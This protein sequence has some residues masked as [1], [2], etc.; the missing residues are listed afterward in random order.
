MKK[1]FYLFCVAQIIIQLLAGKGLLYAQCNDTNGLIAFTG[2]QIADAA[3]PQGQKDK[4]S[5]V[6]LDSLPANTAIRFTDRGYT[7]EPFQSFTDARSD[8]ELVW[9][10]T[11]G[12]SP[13]TTIVITLDGANTIASKGGISGY[14]G[15]FDLGLA[16]DQLFAYVNSPFKI[17]AAML[18]N[19]AGWDTEMAQLE[20]YPILSSSKSLNPNI[21]PRQTVIISNLGEDA[22]QA[23]LNPIT[24]TGSRTALRSQLFAGTFNISNSLSANLVQLSASPITWSA[25]A[26]TYTAIALNNTT[27][28][29]TVSD[30]CYI[31]WQSSTDGTTFNDVIDGAN[32]TG[33]K[34]ANLTLV[35]KPLTQDTWFRMRLT[36]A[37]TTYTPAIHL[38]IPAIS[39]QP[40][41]DMVCT[42]SPTSFTVAATGT[43]LSYQ[44]QVNAGSGFTNIANST[45]YSGATAPTLNISNVT[46]LN[47]YKYRVVVSSNI[48]ISDTSTEA[49]L[50]V[51]QLSV[52]QLADN[53][54]CFGGN[55][56][57]VGLHVLTHGVQPYTYSW[58][59]QGTTTVISTDAIVSGLSAGSYTGTITDAMGC[60]ITR[61][62][63]VEQPAA[64]LEV[65]SHGKTNVSCYGGANGTAR[66]VVTGGTLP[67]TYSWDYAPWIT[68]AEATGLAAGTYTVT[69]TDAKNC[70]TTQQFI[71]TQPAAILSVSFVDEVHVSCHAGT[72]GQ[73]TAAVTGG[74]Q[75]YTYS[76]VRQGTSTQIADTQTASGLTAGTYTVNVTDVNYC[77]IISNFTITQPA[78]ALSV[79]LYNKTDVTAYGGS[80]GTIQVTA[81][82][83][84]PNY[85][86]VWQRQVG[87][88]WTAINQSSN[89][90]TNLTPGIYRVTVT[91]YKG[92][93]Q[94][95]AGIIVTQPPNQAPV[96]SNL[97]SDA[98][99]WAGVGNTVTLDASGNAGVSDAE[100]DALNGGLGNYSG[101][102]LTLQR[103]GN[104]T[105]A[106]VFGFNT[107][108]SSFNVSGNT[109]QSRGSTFATF[110]NTGG[111]LT[112]SFTSSGTVATKALVNEVLQ[113]IMYRNDTP[114]GDA[115]IG[116]TFSD[117]MASSS[118]NVLVN[119][120]NIYITNTI[121]TN[122]INVAD[123]ISFNE[124]I[125]IALADA[126]GTQTL[127]FANTF[128]N[129]TVNILN[130]A[131]S[132]NLT[133]DISNA[134]GLVLTGG[135]ITVSSG[136]IL[137]FSNSAGSAAT[138]SSS[139][140]GNGGINKAGA[141]LITL[142]G[143]G[144]Y[145]GPTQVTA[146]TLSVRGSSISGLSVASGATLAGTGNVKSITL[147]N[148][149]ILSPGASGNDIGT[150]TV[151]ENLQLNAGGTLAIQING[152]TAGTEYDQI[153]V[154]GTVSIQG[155][156]SVTHGYMPGQGD[157]YSIIVNDAADVITGTFTGLP[158]GGTITAAGNST[159]L[160]AS[161]IG[162]TG[163]DFTLTAPI[164]EAPV[165]S[166]LNGDAVSYTEGGAAASIDAGSNATVTDSDS[167]D[168]NGG[169]V[170]VAITAN[171]VSAEDVLSIRNEGTGAGQIGVSGSNVTYG[172]TTIGAWTGG[173]GVNDLVFSFNGNSSVASVQSLIRNL[174]YKNT[175][176]ADPS[177][178][179][180]TVT[181]TVNDGDGGTSTPANVSV[182][183]T[184]VNDA[185]TLTATDLNQTFTEG[186]SAVSLFS[187]T[188]IS[189]IE[190]GQ[191][192]SKLT[193]TVANVSDGNQE[194]LKIDGFDVP[195]VIGTKTTGT[196]GLT[197]DLSVSGSSVIVQLS[198]VG[199]IS[200]AIMQ[201][202]V[203][204]ITYRNTST[205]PNTANRIITLSSIQDNGGIANGGVDLTTLSI[206][207]TVT[208][209]A[210]NNVPIVTTS[211]GNTTY[212]EGTAAVVDAALTVSDP[213]NTTLAS[214]TVAITGNFQSGQDV[215]EFANNGTTMGNITAAY[216]AG[217]G[218]LTL[219][220]AGSTAT[221]AQWQAALRTVKYGNSSQN[222]STANRTISFKVHDSGQESVAATKT[223]SVI[224]V[225]DAPV[226]V[227]DYVTVTEDIPATGNV[228]TND[229]DPEGN[230]LTASLVI[231]P[232]NGT[233]VLNADGSFTYTPNANYA[234]RDSLQ[235]QVCDN[236][237]PSKCDTAWLYL[238]VNPVNDAP[239][240]S[241]P[242][243]IAVTED[244]ASA[245]TGISFS[246]VDA[247]AN[248]V[249]VTLS[250][251]TGTLSATSG[252][253]ITV[254]G[255]AAILT[256]S[257][258]VSDINA[259]VAAGAVTFTTVSNATSNVILTVSI[260]DNAHTGGTALSD[261]KTTPLLVTAVNDAPVNSVPGAQSV[262][263]DATL[264]F[265]SANSNLISISDVDAGSSDVQV[266]LVATN[267]RM[268]LG[269]TSGLLFSV[270]N[271]T[272][273]ASLTFKGTIAN[274]NTALN[275]LVF[276]PTPG[277]N[278]PASLQIIT[279]DLGNSGSGGAKTD[280]DYIAI[281]VN[282]VS[283]K[284]ISVSASTANGTYK[285][286]DVIALTVTFDQTV[287]VNTV[288]G[289]P[290]L[291]LETGA[292]D[293]MSTYVSGSGSNTL[294]FSYTVQPGD[295]SADLDYTSTAAL[296]L[297]GATIENIHNDI[298]ILTLPTV[299][300]SNSIAGQR[301]IVIDGVVPTVAMVAVPTN[302]Y[303]LLNQ[304][305]DFT[306]YFSEAVLVDAI[307]GTPRLSLTIG[308]QTAYADY[309]SGSGSPALVFRY[310][311]AAGLEDHDGVAVGALSLNGGTI[312]DAAGNNAVL[313]L[314]SV[315]NTTGVN[316]DSNPPVVPANFTA[317]G[318]DA[319]ISLA[320]EANMETDFEKYI[321]YV[322]PDGG[323]KTYLT[324]IAK[325]TEYYTYSGLPNGASYEF[326][327]I[328][329]DQ[330]GH[331]SGEAL[332]SAKTMGEQSISF[333]ALANLTYGQQGVVLTASATSNLPVSFVSSDSNIAEVYQDNNDG[334]KWKVNAKKVG[335]VTITAAQGGNNVYLPAASVP[336]SLTIVPAMLTV[337][338]D[339][340][341]KVYG[342]VDPALTYM[343]KASDLRNGDAA[344]VVSGR[345][346]RA[347]GEAVGNHDITNVDLAA[348]N[349]A[350]NYVKSQLS[351]T[352][353][354]LTVTAD[355]KTKVYGGAD[356]ALTYTVKASDLRNGDAATVVS[357]S[358]TRAQG[359]AVGNYDITNVDLAASNYAINYVKSALSITKA[360]LTVTADAKTKVYGTNDPALTYI[361]TGFKRSDSKSILIGGLTRVEGENV[362]SYAIQRGTLA[363]GDNYTI[364]Y[365]GANLMITKATLSGL[366][367]VN[368]DVVYDGAVKSIQLNGTLPTGV[369]VVYQNNDKIN[370]G[371]YDVK[372][373]I[374]ET[375][376]YFGTSF[377]A[378]LL[379][380]KAKQTIS[381]MAPEVLA[382]D[383][384]KISL[385]VQSSSNLPV[386][387][388]VD[389]PMVATVSGTD[390]NVLRL[391]T[392]RITAT[393]AG[394]ENYEAAAPVNVSV[395]VA[396]DASAKLPIIV[397]QAVSPNG[398]GIN[399]FLIIEGIRDYIDNKVTIFDKNGVVLAEIQ[400]YD[401][402]DRVFFGKDH[403]DGTYY[404]YIDVKDG[405]TWKREK[406]FFVIKR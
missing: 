307:G 292:I 395:R 83:G 150:L 255:T 222:P 54:S 361:A 378:T 380:R 49:T 140:Y 113:R 373:I 145:T 260:T 119:T 242:T 238:T 351:I 405:N 315:G 192:I 142:I 271:G 297:N 10:S 231:A 67:Y 313:T 214:A 250:V 139:I 362:G 368:K 320:W 353:A 355:A 48:A 26:P 161:Y 386:Q 265:N 58:V 33:A 402:R 25:S 107:L 35:N 79:T 117:G 273:D 289:T 204:G 95:S 220:S 259:F 88:G 298:A 144:S 123:G 252:M 177:T 370:A 324:D 325:G 7:G 364:S 308:G 311:V 134:S 127:I 172:G 360:V 359:E 28:S 240:V 318:Q 343:V 201:G 288:G 98:V 60:S 92:C 3:N 13:S 279:D 212:T 263:Q 128:A 148:G 393:Q 278:G 125:A 223:V 296:S 11:Q 264:V 63:I 358:L 168:F 82:G 138:I 114:A 285:I 66:V 124:A 217:T 210:V 234:G 257:G 280:T 327:L 209:V 385:D 194:I 130:T 87:A 153:V 45:L 71:I 101:A 244:V 371:S 16:G 344:T 19:K 121:D 215:L 157:N 237:V 207:S 20:Y 99:A 245:L 179:V 146:G 354:V 337:T 225:N 141:G 341:T 404:Y 293:R 21:A 187:G 283:P 397:H 188:T 132:E 339:A 258:S 122:T 229:S 253:G 301:A 403:R 205:N 183:I 52:Q 379:I 14:Q 102:S 193:L 57:K 56:G 356:P 338:A 290:T 89:P 169:N 331:Q 184:A 261:S 282:S 348:D 78:S 27:L 73:V 17:H 41:S 195:L 59:R 387:L 249:T 111:V 294:T 276:T 197:L 323:V 135:P 241:V 103:G 100:M 31:Q 8:G 200:P 322:K 377:N 228:L 178:S 262:D 316:V 77:Q 34:T 248:P 329:I 382:R 131:I 94:T 303:Y 170:R 268:T 251:P 96:I 133:L 317:T 272:N 374:A 366:S 108:N 381:F 346:T 136:N 29:S 235:Y 9:T 275:G 206:A 47:N 173:T 38:T 300:G 335:T 302:G 270:G 349:Y 116:F 163:N 75:P 365:T 312:T 50:S 310:T 319:Q 277:Y 328:A 394:N 182:Q 208:I 160:T 390:L 333:A 336:Q 154:N 198:K 155:T 391:G 213:D 166:N 18:I 247:G 53:V 164:N 112:I 43:A 269:S 42:N 332:A 126:T 37:A 165:I 12:I 232:V 330:R 51:N 4:F 176:T 129:Q 254:G 2:Y 274:I 211:G 137:T 314:N 376:N 287:M 363:A 295:I 80:D 171:R 284:V 156:L 267:G 74:T 149:A 152:V 62:I 104:I 340:K 233:V 347:Q 85:S 400:G 367:F 236:G 369:T 44:W 372:A 72:N 120:D 221:L 69:V 109:L 389:D 158:E 304:N 23:K 105:S 190:V 309:L 281:T 167:P 97:N 203:N 186:A 15:N 384:G 399:E 175:N 162:G 68:T 81:S 70:Q 401:N 357:G 345:L 1:I 86:Y 224:A 91:D 334:G 181:V 106:D 93:L 246:D 230:A 266:N 406:G 226:A 65:S 375:A 199:G 306:I 22:Y 396:N 392:V 61:T 196:N 352:K 118:A 5:F 115:T 76:W 32:F 239:V 143:V 350:I 159:I 84:T 39:D 6:V 216:N 151:N 219:S 24:L 299:G 30:A 191:A 398:D 388:M 90:A 174:E 291:L 243:S 147:H 189:T 185:P 227:D 383:A 46:L 180:R 55:D 36:G 40:D 256:L 218:M 342:E 202:I 305:L 286:D 110:T 321:L 326:F 64:P